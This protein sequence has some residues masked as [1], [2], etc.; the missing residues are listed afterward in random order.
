MVSVVSGLL[1]LVAVAGCGG[2]GGGAGAGCPLP[3]TYVASMTRSA[4][5]GTCPSTLQPAQIDWTL[6]DIVLAPGQA[7]EHTHLDINSTTTNDCSFDAS[8][9]INASSTGYTGDAMLSVTCPT[10]SATPCTANFK[11]TYTKQ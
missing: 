1:G 8:T 11:V 10:V 6:D 4:D 2:E 7:C 5:P 9:T 3:G